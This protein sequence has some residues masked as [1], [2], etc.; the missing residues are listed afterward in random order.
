[1]FN[2]LKFI[3][4]LHKKK[5]NIPT[6]PSL[7]TYLQ[8]SAMRRSVNIRFTMAY[9]I[10]RKHFIVFFLGYGHVV[11]YSKTGKIATIL[12]TIPSIAVSLNCL[13]ICAN[14]LL[15]I[16]KLVITIFEVKILKRKKEDNTRIEHLSVK[17]FI[18]QVVTAVWLWISSSLIAYTYEDLDF[19]DS[20]YF[21]L[22]SL[23][24]VGFG[25]IPYTVEKYLNKPLIFIL[26]F[27]IFFYGMAVMTSVITSFSEVINV[28]KG[29]KT[30]KNINPNDQK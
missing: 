3:I 11:T 15:T 27:T 16:S 9:S 22:I 10:N 6:L 20:V 25:D 5:F 8:I 1:M 26:A 29:K 7:C 19:I 23:T 2:S 18:L 28:K 12:Y 14:I 4:I 13:T 21:V 30:R 17:V 24:T